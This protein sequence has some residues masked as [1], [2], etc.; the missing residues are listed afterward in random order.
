MK[1]SQIIWII[2]CLLAVSVTGAEQ[3]DALKGRT[4][5]AEG[6]GVAGAL[7]QQ[8]VQRPAQANGDAQPGQQSTSDSAGNFTFQP[9]GATAAGAPQFLIARKPGLGAAWTQVGAVAGAEVRLALLPPSF[10]A[11]QVVD[12]GD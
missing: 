12:E 8:Y 2:G 1:M 10:L 11:G 4:V 3:S 5:D 9:S 7:V 6:H